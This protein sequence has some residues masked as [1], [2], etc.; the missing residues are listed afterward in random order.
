MSARR[1][2][3]CMLIFLLTVCGGSHSEGAAPSIGKTAPAFQLEDLWGKNFKSNR[4]NGQLAVLIVGRS[5]KAAPPCKEWVLGIIKQQGQKLPVY[6]VIVVDKA[7]YVPKKLVI[8]S[9]KDFTPSSQYNRVLLDWGTR[10][11]DLFA[12]AQH[13]DPVVIIIDPDGVLRF[14]QRGQLTDARLKHVSQLVATF[15]KQE[16]H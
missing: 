5:R 14:Q 4:L 1:P 13:D 3:L 16:P 8:N 11:A 9:V 10:F 15:T 6:Q 7:W 12:I 2:L